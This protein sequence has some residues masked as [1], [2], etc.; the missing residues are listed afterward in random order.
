MPVRNVSQTPKLILILLVTISLSLIMISTGQGSQDVSAPQ[1]ITKDISCAKCGMFPAKYPK[2]Q[3][4]IVFNDG[5]MAPFDGCKC[6]FGFLF[7]MSEYDKKHTSADVGDVW[8]REF[9]TGDWIDAKKAHYVIGSGE[10]GPMGKELIPF[11][12]AESAETFQ[13]EHG[14][15]IAQYDAIN[16]ETL[17][18]L[19]GKM[20]MNGKMKKKGHMEMGS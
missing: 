2:W 18:P 4:Q 20:H 7:K 6:M 14:G 8:V 1:E 19:M 5:E 10:M 13:K 17:K 15:Q 3:T 16:M 12:D 11:A 9:N